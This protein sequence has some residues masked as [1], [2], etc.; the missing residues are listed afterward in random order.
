M[1]NNLRIVKIIEGTSVDGPGLRTSIYVA[2][3]RHQCPG[4][5]N[6]STW[7]FT[8]GEDMTVEEVMKIVRYNGFNVTFSGG[9][10]LYSAESL[11]PLATAIK[12]EGFGL[13]IYTGFLYEELIANGSDA[14]KQIIELADVL[15]DG[16]FI[17]RLKDTSLIFR[18][19]SNQRII[20]IIQSKKTG[21]TI[22]YN[23]EV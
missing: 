5:H 8:A 3:C 16:P 21:K 2:G 15:V 6:P 20:D 1:N 13:W 10:P 4:C 22:L 14:Q 11:L 23:I 9:D 17:E 7:D 19:S 18:G 12:E